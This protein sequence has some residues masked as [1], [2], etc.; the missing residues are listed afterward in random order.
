MKD[1]MENGH[2]IELSY[3]MDEEDDTLQWDVNN[4]QDFADRVNYFL[5]NL[6]LSLKEGWREIQMS[7]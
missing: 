7:N 5:Q 2:D 4:T 3:A 6:K 1:V